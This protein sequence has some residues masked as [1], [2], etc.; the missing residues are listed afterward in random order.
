VTHRHKK[1]AQETAA[2][3]AT[4]P[5]EVVSAGTSTLNLK[6]PTPV[7]TVI[8]PTE[9]E[10]RVQA[11]LVWESRGYQGSEEENWLIAERN[12]WEGRTPR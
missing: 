7:A 1:T 2:L 5:E 4:T 8:P 3:A 11:Y 12:L 9:H 10:I 6:T